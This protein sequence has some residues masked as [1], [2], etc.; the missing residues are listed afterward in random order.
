MR[1]HGQRGPTEGLHRKEIS[2]W[3]WPWTVNLAVKEAWSGE[4]KKTEVV[5]ISKETIPG[6]R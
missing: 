4:G 2:A 6:S 1:V 5:N 3:N